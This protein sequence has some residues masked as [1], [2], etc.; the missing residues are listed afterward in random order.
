MKC[1]VLS[2]LVV[3]FSTVSLL[4]AARAGVISTETHLAVGK[5]TAKNQ[6]QAALERQDVR[7]QL[8]SLGVDPEKAK[9]RVAN[10]TQDE[11][12]KLQSRIG[13]L[14]AGA[15][16]IEVIGILFIVLLILELVGVINIF[17]K[18]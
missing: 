8:I 9:A 7:T 3:F 18:L 11:V 1:A 6:L 14:P 2:L 4:P 13:D 16:A 17:H 5:L 10:L 12:A 15:G